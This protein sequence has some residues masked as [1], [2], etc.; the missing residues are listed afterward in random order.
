MSV[1][2]LIVCDIDGK[3]PGAI[4]LKHRGNQSHATGVTDLGT[5]PANLAQLFKD[6]VQWEEECCYLMH[7]ITAE[8]CVSS[9]GKLINCVLSMKTQLTVSTL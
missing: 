8:L 3:P 2:R 6:N 9:Q 7:H 5:V 1:Q 4:V